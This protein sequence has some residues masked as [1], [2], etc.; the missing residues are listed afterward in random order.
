MI[1]ALFRRYKFFFFIGFAIL[2]I[3][4]Y[5]A[6][7]SI[8]IPIESG[9]RENKVNIFEETAVQKQVTQSDDEDIINSNIQQQDVAHKS[10]RSSLKL[11]SD[12]KFIPSC[13]ILND[14]EV[15]SAVQRARSQKCKEFIIDVACQIKSEIFYPTNLPNTCEYSKF[16]EILKND[17]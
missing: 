6:Y 12:L 15:L 5:L 16:L 10:E 14:K 4:I 2:A 3:Q 9:H 8:K 17:L 13:D 11:V 7:K 1:I